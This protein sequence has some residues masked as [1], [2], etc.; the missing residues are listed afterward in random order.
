MQK[1]K[2]NLGIIVCLF[3]T[4]ILQAREFNISKYGAVNDGKTINTVAVQKAIDD[5]TKNG[6]G[7]VMVDGG[8]IYVIGTI[9]MK[10]N[11]TLHIDNGTVLQGSKYQEDYAKEGVH[12]VMYA[13]ETTKD[14]CLIYAENATSFAIE[15]HGTIDGNGHLEYFPKKK[16]KGKLYQRPMLLRFKDCSDISMRDIHLINPA[17]WTSVWLYCNNITIDGITIISRANFNGDGL[18]FDGCQDVRVS[19]SSFDNS[20]DSIC[21]QASLPNKPCRNITV[22]NC[23]FTTKWGGMRIGLLSRGNIEY[24]TVSNCTFKD[25]QD[26]GLKIQQMEGGEMSNMTFSNLVMENVP[27]PIFMTFC[28]QTAS[29]DTPIGTYE[30]LKRMH[31]MKFDN[32][33]VD[34]SK[35]DRHSAFFLTGIPGHEIE[36]ISITNVDFI[37]SGG[38]S[39]EDAKQEKV[40]EYTLENMKRWPEFFTVGSL[41]VFGIYARHMNGLNLENI[42]IRTNKKDMRAPVILDNVKNVTT[43]NIKVNRALIKLK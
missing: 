18:D 29:V 16:V 21:L 6:G 10:S 23:N 40:K 5:C 13:R 41:P 26:S 43:R 12:K 4:I 25:I 35:G 11:V 17:S 30:P 7:T 1:L 14:L 28:Q 34:N 24:V 9:F 15:G 8:G 2:R 37:V 22:T 19:N 38:V 42:S 36:D 31:N 32:I 3:F 39:K 20:D 27:R 33:I